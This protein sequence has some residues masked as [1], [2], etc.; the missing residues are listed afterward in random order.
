M[1]RDSLVTSYCHHRGQGPTRCVSLPHLFFLWCL[2]TSGAS[3]V[4]DGEQGRKE[5]GILTSAGVNKGWG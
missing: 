4:C 1:C 5:W 3:C 2:G